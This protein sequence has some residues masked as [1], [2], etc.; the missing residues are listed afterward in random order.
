M[1]TL[2]VGMARFRLS[3]CRLNHL[4][5]ALI[6][7]FISH[8]AAE[9]DG[10]GRSGGRLGFELDTAIEADDA[11]GEEEL[12]VFEASPS[13][14]GREATG[15]KG[16]EHRPF[17]QYGGMRNRMIERSDSES[18]CLI[19]LPRFN[20]QSALPDRRQ[21]QFERQPLGN[22]RGQTESSNACLGQNNCI[23]FA[24]VDFL[25]PRIDV[26]ADF[27]DL[28]IRPE[29]KQLGLSA[30]AARADRGFLRE[31][32]ER[33]EFRG[34]QHVATSRTLGNGCKAKLRRL[35]GGQILQA[36]H[37]GVDAAV[38]QGLLNFLGEN[39]LAAEGGQRIEPPVA[40]GRDEQHFDIHGARA[41][42]FG[43]PIG[44]PS[45]ECAAASSETKMHKR[46]LKDEG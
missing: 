25:E 38:E 34:D 10:I 45:G 42:L 44:L 20:R 15:A 28:K 35:F 8:A 4:R 22:F 26:A 30:V 5:G 16:R 2:V 12:I 11:S 13:G 21:E 7:Q 32:F 29:V 3:P 19:V 17:G 40:A 39:A 36:M 33:A 1:P 41:Q 14:D 37:G 18:C 31:V 46:S 6:E 27:L 43:D 24:G 23:E 9:S